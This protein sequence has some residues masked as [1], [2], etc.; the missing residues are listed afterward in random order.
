MRK[1]RQLVTKIVRR[2]VAQMIKLQDG[3]SCMGYIYI[4]YHHNG[5]VVVHEKFTKDDDW[6]CIS[7]SKKIKIGFPGDTEKAMVKASI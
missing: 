2:G 7:A 6:E 1:P 4:S 3:E 5:S